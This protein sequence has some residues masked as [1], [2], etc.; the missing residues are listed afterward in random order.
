MSESASGEASNSCS[1]NDKDSS[2][3]PTC[4]R[5]DFASPTG[6]KQHHARSHGESLSGEKVACSYCGGVYRETPSRIERA[7]HNYCSTDCYD[8]HKTKRFEGKDNPAYKGGGYVE[9]EWCSDEFWLSPASDYKY[10]SHSCSSKAYHSKKDKHHNYNSQFVECHTCGSELERT[11]WRIERQ[12]K[13]FCNENCY[14]KYKSTLIGEKHPSYNGG[15][16]QNYGPNWDEQRDKARKR[17]N[18]NC[19]RC[20]VTE[21]EQGRE[22]DVHHIKRIGWFKDN[23][24]EPEWYERGNDLDNLT[25]YCRGCH[26]IWEGIP[27]RIDNR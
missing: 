23:Y 9:C 27:L 13:H 4:G 1:D 6:M 21:S 24:E 7:K 19:Q 2:V 20:G 8:N 22:M 26:Q 5:D 12:D 17:D 18:Y 3:C 25:C 16:G 11:E 15:Y 10:C 14:T